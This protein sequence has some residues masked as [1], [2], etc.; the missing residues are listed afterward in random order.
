MRH[1]SSVRFP[2]G[3]HAGAA[4]LVLGPVSGDVDLAAADARLIGEAAY[5]H[6]GRSV[7]GAGDVDGDGFDDVLVGASGNDAGAPDAGA[8]YLVLATSL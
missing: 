8:A 6:A 7:S 4:Y 3:W 1:R 5:E 2:Q